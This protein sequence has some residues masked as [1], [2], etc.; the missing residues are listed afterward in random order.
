M[1]RLEKKEM[2]EG[3]KKTLEAMRAMPLRE[4]RTRL[5][6]LEK[7]ARHLGELPDPNERF[8]FN[9]APE[10][11]WTYGEFALAYVLLLKEKRRK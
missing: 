1:D 10:R 3:K 2:E 8:A 9:L 7:R 5:Q 11:E 4:K 6:L